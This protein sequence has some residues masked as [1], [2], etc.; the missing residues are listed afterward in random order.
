M[1]NRRPPRFVRPRKSEPADTLDQALI[2]ALL[3]RPCAC[4]CECAASE[5]DAH[6]CRTCGSKR[7][8]VTYDQHGDRQASEE[9][10]A[11][12]LEAYVGGNALALWIESWRREAVPEDQRR[13][14]PCTGEIG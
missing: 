1:S 4:H 11:W 9:R 12:L 5:H 8:A 10:E 6:G 3:T 14:V 2:A 7:C 13:P